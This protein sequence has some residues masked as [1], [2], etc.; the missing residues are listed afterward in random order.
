VHR[1]IVRADIERSPAVVSALTAAS[2]AIEDRVPDA[3]LDNTTLELGA[4]GGEETVTQVLDALNPP[5]EESTTVV[6]LNAPSR[7]EAAARVEDALA[8]WGEV[9]VE[10]L[11]EEPI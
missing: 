9:S 1:Y 10:V 3:E 2:M 8:R 6:A 4:S 7:D 5:A 11:E